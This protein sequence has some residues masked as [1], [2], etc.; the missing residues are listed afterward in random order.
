MSW[1]KTAQSNNPLKSIHEVDDTLADNQIGVYET[2]FDVQRYVMDAYVTKVALAKTKTKYTVTFICNH[3][4]LGSIAFDCYWA[5]GLDEYKRAKIVYD[6][7]IDVVKKTMEM[8]IDEE[9]PT[10]MFWAYM[11]KYLNKIDPEAIA[12]T[13]I[14]TVNYARHIENSPDWRRN[15][16]GTRYP[17]YKEESYEQYLNTNPYKKR[18]L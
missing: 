5:F 11:K 15:I 16:Y 14:P 12:H 10:S 7:V 18:Q 2:L 6:E 9:M 3:G 13:N 4:F 8:F 17:T 1:Y